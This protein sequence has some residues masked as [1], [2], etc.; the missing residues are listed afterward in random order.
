[1]GSYH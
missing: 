1:M